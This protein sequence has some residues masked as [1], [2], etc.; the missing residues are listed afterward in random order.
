[1]KVEKI[2]V[3][4]GNV[5]KLYDNTRHNV[6]FSAIDRIAVKN[7]ID[8][9]FSKKLNGL[10]GTGLINGVSCLLLK[11]TTL[12]NNSGI[13]VEKTL[14]FYKLKIDD[15]V[16]VIVDDVAF[17]IGKIKIKIKGSDGG[18]N[19]LK[20]LIYETGSENFSRIRIGVGKLQNHNQS[21]AS[22]V[23]SKFNEDEQTK[24]N[25]VLVMVE[26]AVNLILV[27][28]INQAMNKFN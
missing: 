10:V 22:W 5:G 12:M 3:G 21:L 1:M 26:Q 24:L 15:D 16:V 8:F 19:G 17:D 13:A 27:G 4:L 28:K 20:S 2:I 6:G 9:K 25:K 14:N 23:L 11:P 7:E 18:H